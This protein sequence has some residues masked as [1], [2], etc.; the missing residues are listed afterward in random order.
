MQRFVLLRIFWARMLEEAVGT[1][2]LLMTIVLSSETGSSEEIGARG[3]LCFLI[4]CLILIPPAFTAQIGAGMK[5]ICHVLK[6]LLSRG[7]SCRDFVVVDEKVRIKKEIPQIM[8]C[9]YP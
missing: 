1:L 5:T 7:C 8:F 2:G 6:S 4:F 9:E 3:D